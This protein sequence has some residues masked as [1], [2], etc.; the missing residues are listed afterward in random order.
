MLSVAE[1]EDRVA[2]ETWFLKR[3]LPSV[4]TRR[5]RWRRLWQ[6]SAPMLAGFATTAVAA[7]IIAIATGFEHVDIDLEP[8]RAEWVVLA[9]LPSIVP[10]A[11]LVGWLVSRIDSPRGRRITS[12]AAVV[13]LLVADVINSSARDAFEDVWSTVSFVAVVLVLTGLGVGSILGWAV[14]LTTSHLAST[15]A[16]A[17]RALPVVLLTVLVFFNSYVWA[18]ATLISR[19][20]IWLVIAFL[21][22]VAIAFVVSGLLERVRPVLSSSATSDSDDERLAATPFEAMPDP[23]EPRPLTRGEWFNVV[24]V[25]AASQIAQILTVALVTAAIFFTLGLLVLSQPILADWTK[26][27]GSAQGTVLGMT[28]PV[29]QALIHVTMF[30]GAMTFMYVS[31][32]A[33]GDGEYRSQFLDPLIDDLHLTLVARNRYR[34]AVSAR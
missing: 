19:T 9:V 33:V 10:V 5:A 12:T 32:R 25:A 16:L 28:L 3:G 7:L 24:F 8:T 34:T 2:A 6:R 18:M 31:A 23:V 17:L 14:R 30:I 22:L 11:L 21:T 26:Q 1:T 20:R 27:A 29:P 15:A 13:V 4:L